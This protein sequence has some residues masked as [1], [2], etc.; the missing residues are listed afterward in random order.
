MALAVMIT[1]L[2]LTPLFHYTPL[3]VLSSIII[4]AML[5]LIDYE[6][7]FHL[8]KVDKIDFCVCI[9][10]YFGVVFGSVE[11]GLVTAVCIF[12]D[13]FLAFFEWSDNQ[14]PFSI[15][16]FNWY[17]CWCQCLEF[18]CS[19]QGQG[20]PCWATFRIPWRIEE[21]I[22]ILERRA[23]LVCLCLGL[24][25]QSILLMPITWERGIYRW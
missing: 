23:S 16:Y 24:T 15:N 18:C 17:R 5:G 8:W 1:L 7:A 6:A 25:P 19:L 20:Q 10:A 14:K 12:D 22:S 13:H 21:W 2:F 11:I 9:G 3:V 4:S